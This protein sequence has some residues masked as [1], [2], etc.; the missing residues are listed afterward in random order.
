M[1]GKKAT[2]DG[3]QVSQ[4][5]VT[6]TRTTVVALVPASALLLTVQRKSRRC[7][8][9]AEEHVMTGCEPERTHVFFRGFPVRHCSHASIYC[10]GHREKGLPVPT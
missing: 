3:E 7:A 1:S 4:E 5:G 8:D 2:N 9:C 6:R 10:Y